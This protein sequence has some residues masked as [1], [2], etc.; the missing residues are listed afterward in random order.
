MIYL[1]ACA[2][3]PTPMDTEVPTEIPA[4]PTSAATISLCDP[5]QFIDLLR[6]S[7]PYAE[8]VVSYNHFNDTANLTAWFVD[9]ALNQQASGSE[10]QELT[11]L[12]F[13]HA[14]EISHLLAVA[15]PCVTALFDS[16]TVIAVDDLYHAWYVGAVPP[17]RIPIA[18]SLS[19]DEWV[20]LEGEFDAGYQRTKEV[21]EGDPSEVPEGSCAWPEARQNL[22][23]A[24]TQS[25]KNGAL[26]YY[27]EPEDASVYVQWD[28]PPVASSPQQILDYFFLPLPY[29]DKAVSCLY[30]PFDT[31]WLFYI[32][33]DGEAQ[34]IFAID[35]DAV[36]DDDHQVFIDQMELIYQ[37]PAQ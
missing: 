29:I 4:Q 37:T 27:I 35:G 20:R 10:I 30:P 15:E 25:Q 18:E 11:E 34:W 28:V 22:E 9:P 1:T 5:A 17:S 36:R 7:V 13:R 26:Y 16:L 12:T 6:Q 24:F 14:V 32:R 21:P 19:E 31:L 2:T 23:Q 3:A 33:Q 8:S